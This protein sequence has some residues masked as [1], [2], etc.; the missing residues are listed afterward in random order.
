[1]A[2]GYGGGGGGGC[3][4]DSVTCP[5]VVVGSVKL[6]AALDATPSTTP[7]PGVAPPTRPTP[8]CTTPLKDPASVCDVLVAMSVEVEVA[9]GG[10]GG[11][12]TPPNPM[13][14]T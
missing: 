4:N 2:L 6:I 5:F 8:V 3:V 14:T 11:A 12:A 7:V 9:D 10:R 1:M 13:P